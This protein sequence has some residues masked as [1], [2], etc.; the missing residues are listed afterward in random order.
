M[1]SV[2]IAVAF[3][4]WVIYNLMRHPAFL[5]TAI[6]L[7]WQFALKVF[8]TV[9]LD[10]FG[11]IYSD[12]V[13]TA[14]GGTGTSA[15]LMILFVAIPLV[16]IM[17]ATTRF[18]K[19]VR[20]VREPGLD[21]KRMTQ[22]DLIYAV[23][24]ALLVFLYGDMLVIGEIPLFSGIERF[25]YKGGFFHEFALNFLFLISYVMGY[26]VARTRLLEGRWD[27]R[28]GLV[29]LALFVYL[30]FAGHRFG[31]FYLIVSFMLLP[32]GA[33]Y[34][35]PKAKILVAAPAQDVS[36]L[37]R[38][39]TSKTTAFLFALALA[40]IVL[41][42][43]ANSLLNVR[44]GDPVDALLQRFLVQPVHLYW[45]TWERW[46]ADEMNDLEAGLNFMF[47][48][49]FDLTRNSGIQYLMLIH[50]G[51]ANASRVFEF[52]SVDYAGGYPEILM[53]VGG[54]WVGLVAAILASAVTAL[55]YRVNLLAV[56]RGHVLTAI[57]S[58]YVC[59]GLVNLFLGGMLN[60][61]TAG[62]YWIKITALLF[63]MAL[64]IGFERSGRRFLPWVLVAGHRRKAHE[65]T[66][67]QP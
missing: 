30:F 55:L 1:I 4:A 15:L 14:V 62:S 41:V 29:L 31:S 47:R 60:F 21:A 63:V 19:P 12:E 54:L 3:G 32:I 64:E 24:V 51:S 20:S 66:L 38:L 61:M 37:Q 9:Y 53:E 17:I 44:D 10:V 56:A 34:V 5:M 57:M 25:E 27:V 18:R 42:A 8:G 6:F 13:Y 22:A 40:C 36:R 49:P 58:V 23:S 45:L 2:T 7:L 48:D 65:A 59:F 67:P 11:P 43:V 52:Q 46:Q 26:A 39:L 16:L 35:A 28:F 50:L 33:F